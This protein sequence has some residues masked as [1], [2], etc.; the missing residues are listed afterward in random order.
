MHQLEGGRLG[1]AGGGLRLFRWEGSSIVGEHTTLFRDIEHEVDDFLW[2]VVI[3][4]LREMAVD[5]RVGQ[6]GA[7]QKG[8]P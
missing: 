7:Q 4:S 5:G 6:E 2:C 1:K 3:V 8:L